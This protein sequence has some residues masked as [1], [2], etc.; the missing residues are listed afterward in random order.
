MVAVGEFGHH[1]VSEQS[2]QRGAPAAE[3]LVVANLRSETQVQ[4]AHALGPVEERNPQRAPG[5]LVGAAHDLRELVAPTGRCAVDGR[6]AIRPRRE[7]TQGLLR[8]IHDQQ[9]RAHPELAYRRVGQRGELIS[10]DEVRPVGHRHQSA[11]PRRVVGGL[12]HRTTSS[13]WF[14][15]AVGSFIRHRASHTL[16]PEVIDGPVPRRIP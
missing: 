11:P 14:R 5:A 8:Q 16:S 4:H 15:P 1:D 7:R 6:R 2:G 12:V 10:G 9:L 13:T 3:A